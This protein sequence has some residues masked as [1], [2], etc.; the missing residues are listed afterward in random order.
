VGTR[1]FSR[2]DRW[3]LAML[4]YVAPQHRIALGGFGSRRG[5][6]LLVEKLAKMWDRRLAGPG[7]TPTG[8]TPVPPKCSL[9]YKTGRGPFTWS[10]ARFKAS[11][12]MVRVR[13]C[14]STVFAMLLTSRHA[15]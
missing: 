12:K 10:T 1:T 7:Q 2:D 3:A 11:N 14:Q 5:R 13:F 9:P 8:E 4:L 15:A 6:G